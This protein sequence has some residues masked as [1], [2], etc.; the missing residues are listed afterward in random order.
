MKA[1]QGCNKHG[2]KLRVEAVEHGRGYYAKG[3]ADT[4]YTYICPT[5]K[6]YH[7]T[8]SDSDQWRGSWQCK[9]EITRV[10]SALAPIDITGQTCHGVTV[11]SYA[12]KGFWHCQCLCGRLVDVKGQ[13]LRK[14]DGGH[15]GGDIMCDV[16][17]ARVTA[18]VP[19]VPTVTL[20]QRLLS[21]FGL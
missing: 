10:G 5:C 14:A 15:F 11:I 21:V 13:R 1:K 16:C 8:K 19:T 20:W 7:I 4:L 3:T 18:I 2:F 17:W 12:G 6:L 9:K